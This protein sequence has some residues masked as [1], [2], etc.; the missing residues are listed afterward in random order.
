MA[1]SPRSVRYPLEHNRIEAG[2]FGVLPCAG[3]DAE[4]V[5]IGTVCEGDAVRIG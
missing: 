1:R 2:E 3:L 5:T 4:V